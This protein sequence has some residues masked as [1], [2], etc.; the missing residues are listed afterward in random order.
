MSF[1]RSVQTDEDNR[2]V[3]LVFHGIFSKKAGKVLTGPAYKPKRRHQGT[4]LQERIDPLPCDRNREVELRV[5]GSDQGGFSPYRVS[6]R[7]PPC[8]SPLVWLRRPRCIR[9][10]RSK[11]GL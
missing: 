5:A 9:K 3:I 11:E 7:F 8:S 10:L 1:S 2:K 4:F 6:V